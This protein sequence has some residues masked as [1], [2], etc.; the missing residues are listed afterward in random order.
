MAPLH[1]IQQQIYDERAGKRY[2]VLSSYGDAWDVVVFAA[3]PSPDKPPSAWAG[4]GDATGRESEIADA[5]SAGMLHAES[6][7]NGGLKVG[8]EQAFELTHQLFVHVPKPA[9]IVYLDA[10]DVGKHTTAL[11]DGALNLVSRP[12]ASGDGQL[13]ALQVQLED[14]DAEIAALQAKLLNLKATAAR[15]GDGGR[16]AT[17]S[18]GSPT[19]KAPPPKNAS[20]LQP[21]QKR[22]KLVQDHF[23]SSSDDDDDDDEDDEDEDDE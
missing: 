15:Q 21:N 23:A 8:V 1:N 2:L 22:R 10:E 11:L 6:R 12:A 17:G 16:F 4:I 19:K 7:P 9:V 3:S 5:I 13:R 18:K 20:M 14:K